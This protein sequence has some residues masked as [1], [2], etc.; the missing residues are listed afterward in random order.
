MKRETYFNGDTDWD[1]RG[2]GESKIVVENDQQ[3]VDG[4]HEDYLWRVKIM[5]LITNYM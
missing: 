1:V 3:A 2:N 4:R 5:R